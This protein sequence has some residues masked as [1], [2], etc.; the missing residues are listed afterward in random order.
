VNEE[1]TAERQ[2]GVSEP[3]KVEL[4][5]LDLTMFEATSLTPSTA[6]GSGDHYFVSGNQIA[7]ARRVSSI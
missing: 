2:T 4:L 7:S 1:G 6:P 5:V 3:Q